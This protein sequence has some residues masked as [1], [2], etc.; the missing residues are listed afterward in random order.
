MGE[1]VVVDVSVSRR[2]TPNVDVVL[3]VENLFD[4]QYVVGLAG[5]E[6]IGQPRYVHG[7]LRFQPGR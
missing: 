4:K 2:L 7:G 1:F 3:G 5:V 6:T